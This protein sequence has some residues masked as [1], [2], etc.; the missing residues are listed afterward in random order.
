[1]NDISGLYGVGYNILRNPT[2]LGIEGG[3]G[4]ADV[5][6][7]NVRVKIKDSLIG[8]RG[9]GFIIAE[10]CRENSEDSALL[11]SLCNV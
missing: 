5:E 7:K 9:M 2:L 8:Q 10:A 4:H 1:M 3:P 6:Y 11:T